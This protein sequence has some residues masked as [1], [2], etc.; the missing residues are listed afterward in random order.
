MA[1]EF[2]IHNG[3]M[4][5][6]LDANGFKIK[7]LPPGS[8]F[9]QVQSD[10][11]QTDTTAPDFIKNKPTLAAV[12]TSGSYDDLL[13]KPTIP[14]PVAVDA[15]LAAQGA[16]ADAKA[17]GDALRGGFTEWEF[18]GL[19]AGVSVERIFYSEPS[20]FVFLSDGSGGFWELPQTALLLDGAKSE[21]AYGTEEL[22]SGFTAVRHLVTPTKT[23][24][25]TNDSGFLTQHQDISG[26]LDGVAA[27]PAWED[28]E[29]YAF[30]AIVSHNGKLWKN[31]EP[32][33][34]EEPS[35]ESSGWVEVSLGDLK[36]DAL[37]SEQLAAVNSGA[38]AAK[39]AA[40]DGYA[41]QI[42]QKANAADVD[43][44]LAQKANT[45]DLPYRLVTPGE[46]EFS[47]VPEGVTDVSLSWN[48]TTWS[49]TYVIG[50]HAY[51]GVLPIRVPPYD[52]NELSLTFSISSSLVTATRAS[53]PGHLADRAGNRVEVT[54]DTT[55]TFPALVNAG[56]L[57]DFLVRLEISGSTVPTIT[58]QG[59]GSEAPNGADEI[60]YET[61]GDTFPVPDE[62]GT[63]SYSFTEN[64]VAH[65]FA[66]SLKAVSVVTQGGS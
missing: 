12:A 58:F 19:P 65:K 50:T 32:D 56:K 63:W 64:C 46:W 54:G 53:L 26:K 38:T 7:N 28:K 10:W 16:A 61:D 44:A 45:A 42:A 29:L 24:Q 23:S 62:A 2:P 31:F 25:L 43:A 34:D 36:Q 39:V 59:Q 51:N 14:A 55:L 49:Y 18:S 37:T 3:R 15:T 5:T 52:G 40:W 27:Y 20:W 8:G 9:T 11:G 13:G 48:G 57:R 30:R 33:N 60:T 66:V 21:S 6:D 1:R 17:V 41:A 47:G 4:T 35:A 22:P